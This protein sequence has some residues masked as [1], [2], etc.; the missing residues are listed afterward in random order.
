MLLQSG[1]EFNSTDATGTFTTPPSGGSGGAVSAYIGSKQSPL[2][3]AHATRSSAPASLKF[4]PTMFC[5]A[6]IPIT[7]TWESR[8]ATSRRQRLRFNGS[9]LDV[10]GNLSL[11][12]F[13]GLTL[14]VSGSNYVALSSSGVELSGPSVATSWPDQFHRGGP[15]LHRD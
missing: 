1:I 2:L 8:A 5:P 9:Q 11:P 12:D 14:A 7:R 15:G 6:P 13:A 4:Q 3:D 10:Q